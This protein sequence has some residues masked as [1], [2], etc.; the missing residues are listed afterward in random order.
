LILKP[1]ELLRILAKLGATI[2]RSHGKGGHVMVKLNDGMT[3]IPTG[4]KEI[5]KGTLHSILRNLKLTQ[6]DLI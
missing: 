3:P 5:K 2:D 4:S 1:S 6:N